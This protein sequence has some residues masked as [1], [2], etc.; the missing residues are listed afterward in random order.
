[1]AERGGDGHQ[2]IKSDLVT[3]ASQHHHHH[4]HYQPG[5]FILKLRDIRGGRL[6]KYL[7]FDKFIADGIKYL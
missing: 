3:T 7:M 4:H 6:E 5:M 2:I 1:M